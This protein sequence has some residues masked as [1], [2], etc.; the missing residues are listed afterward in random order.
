MDAGHIPGLLA[1]VD[2]V[3]AGWVSVAPRS[4]FPTLNRSRV[5]FPVDDK[6][7]WS[8]VCFFVHR[9]YRHTGLMR[10]LI[11]A[12]VAYSRSQGGDIVEAYPYDPGKKVES[13]SIYLGVTSTF[14]E[15]GFIE[16]ARR[17]PTHPIMRKKLV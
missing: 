14:L 7:V 5:L 3:P 13:A 9:K 6:P 2:G 11:D 15:A 10:P 1:Y 12:A 4:E 8:I 16:V 17:S